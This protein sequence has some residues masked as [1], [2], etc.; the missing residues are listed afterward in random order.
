MIETLF[1][2]GSSSEPGVHLHMCA[3]DA[4]R[5]A[6]SM[7]L[8]T[9]NLENARLW[10]EA[11]DRWLNWS[12]AVLGRADGM[13]LWAELHLAE[14]DVALADEFAQ[15]ALTLASDPRQPLALIA[16]HRFLGELST[17]RLAANS[18]K[19]HL[20]QSLELSNACALPFERALTT[21]AIA[22]F[23]IATGEKDAAV[24]HLR[25]VRQTC[26]QLRA[27]PTLKRVSAI[28]H[29]IS[30]SKDQPPFGLTPRE[31]EVLRLLSQGMSD[32]EIA[33]HLFISHHTVMRHVSH[34]LGKLDVE[35]RTAAVAKA[36]R[37]VI[38]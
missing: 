14:G 13:L 9:G 11:H 4:Q 5:V 21:L 19:T 38:S 34:I 15:Q 24:A 22:E 8:V 32:R 23:E 33:D 16:V 3:T 25:E 10:L 37:E 18:A 28:E 20:K 29:L 7:S 2:E 26:E 27:H 31:L 35:S 1:P 17:R 30:K 6:A 12:E 36:V